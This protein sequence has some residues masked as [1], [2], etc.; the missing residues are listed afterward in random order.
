M[1]ITIFSLSLA[2]SAAASTIPAV[3]AAPELTVRDTPEGTIDCN[4]CTGMFDFCVQVR[5][6]SHLFT[7][8]SACDT[9]QNAERSYSRSRRL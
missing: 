9:D 2:L 4:F 7:L 8:S 5:V 3:Q 6:V 1:K